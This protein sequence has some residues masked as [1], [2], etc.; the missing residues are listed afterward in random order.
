MELGTWS[1][2]S[3]LGCFLLL[4]EKHFK[5]GKD[6]FQLTVS[7]VSVHGYLAPLILS[8]C[9]AEHDGERAIQGETTYFVVARM[10][11][12]SGRG[13]GTRYSP[14]TCPLR[15]TPFC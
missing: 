8:L 11:G 2:K 4:S 13:Q 15:P 5:W 10:Q 3:M 6:V 12:K 1:K 7:E 14:R 9:E